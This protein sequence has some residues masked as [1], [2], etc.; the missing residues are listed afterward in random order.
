[1]FSLT[2]LTEWLEE[3]GVKRSRAEIARRAGAGQLGKKVGRQYVV[4]LAEA[5]ALLTS[6]REKGS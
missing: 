6:L 4:P 1:M 3:R 2:E 5:Q